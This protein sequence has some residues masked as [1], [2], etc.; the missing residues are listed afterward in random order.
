MSRIIRMVVIL[1]GAG[2]KQIAVLRFFRDT[3][4]SRLP[5]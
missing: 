5:A 2:K 3:F 1:A 4:E